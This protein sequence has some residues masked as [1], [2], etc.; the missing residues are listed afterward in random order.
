M[1]TRSKIRGM[2]IGGAIGDA[3]GRPVESMSYNQIQK[4]H[5]EGVTDYVAPRANK[6]FKDDKKGVMTDDTQLGIAV[7]KAL[8]RANGFGMGTQAK[9]HVQALHESDEGWGG[10]LR[11]SIT[12]LSEGVRWTESGKT[13]NPNLGSGNGVLMR[14]SPIGAWYAAKGQK[15]LPWKKFADKVVQFS[16]MTHYSV[17]SA[18]AGVIHCTVIEELLWNDISRFERSDFF[19]CVSKGLDGRH[20]KRSRRHPNHYC[21]GHLNDNKNAS[22]KLLHNMIKLY[23]AEE[24]FNVEWAI[25]EF[26][27]GRSFVAYSMPFSYA[28]FIKNP[29]CVE[30]MFKVA[31]AGGDTDTNAKIVGEMLGA[32]HGIELFE[33]PR[34]AHLIEKLDGH[35][36]LYHLADQFCDKFGIKE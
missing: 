35:Q 19:R 31:E 24:L 34:Y 6:W 18:L 23:R 29:Y 32:L 28:F 21:I 20:Y 26:G 3:L 15:R 36:N 10:S 9:Y 14:I 17:I 27:R 33:H 11:T 8:I 7:L 30:T 13:D 22:A 5:P 12:R 25:N 4:H 1:L 16:A 2:L